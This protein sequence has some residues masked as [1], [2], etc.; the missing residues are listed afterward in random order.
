MTVL[1]YSHTGISVRD[2]DVS[3]TFYRDVLDLEV[4]FDAILDGAYLHAILQTPFS[5]IRVARVRVPNS[6]HLELLEYRDATRPHRP[7]APSDPAAGH[8]ALEVTD[9]LQVFERARSAGFAPLSRQPVIVDSGI[10]R[11]WT[12]A[13]LTDPDGYFVEIVQRP[14]TSASA[15]GLTD[16]SRQAESQ[17]ALK[18]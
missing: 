3:L 7:V 18:S 1:G 5:A 9:A 15:T 10:N 6:G 11:G 4:F 8:V 13:Y 12:A 14:P 17:T 16:D 2:M